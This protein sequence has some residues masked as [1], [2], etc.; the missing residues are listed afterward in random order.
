MLGIYGHIS[1]CFASVSML[2]ISFRFLFIFGCSIFEKHLFSKCVTVFV[3]LVL[4]YLIYGYI[5]LNSNSWRIWLLQKLA[6]LN[7]LENE[8]LRMFDP[9]DLNYEK[10]IG[11]N[12]F[13]RYFFYFDSCVDFIHCSHIVQLNI[14]HQIV[15]IIPI[16][17][18]TIINSKTFH[19]QL[20][21]AQTGVVE[22]SV[23]YATSVV[24]VKQGGLFNR[25]F[26]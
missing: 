11:R 23:W 19:I 18:S 25:N 7:K 21:W 4:L 16:L 17:M 5:L 20:S 15:F 10:C 12:D 2:E 1:V 3:K 22:I 13:L 6:H 9:G 8:N 24:R 26:Q 14:C